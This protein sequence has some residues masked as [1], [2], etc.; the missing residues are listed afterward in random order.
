MGGLLIKYFLVGQYGF[1]GVSAQVFRADKICLGINFFWR[2]KEPFFE[3][4][5]I[6]FRSSQSN[7]WEPGV[8][9]GRL[10]HCNG[11]KF[12]VHWSKDREG[13]MRFE[14]QVRIPVGLRSSASDAPG[15]FSAKRRMGSVRRICFLAARRIYLHS[16]FAKSGGFLFSKTFWPRTDLSTKTVRIKNF[17]AGKMKDQHL[18]KI[19]L[20]A[21]A[22]LFA[23]QLVRA[24]TITENFTNDPAA[25]GW[26]VFGDTSLFQWDSVSHNLDVTWNS[27]NQNSYFYLPLGTTLTASADF[28]V[29]FDLQLSTASASGYG[30]EL[31]AGFFN[32]AEATNAFFSRSSGDN[33]PDL[34]EFDYFP[35]AGF[36]DTIWPALVDSN[37]HFNYNGPSDYAIYTP[38]LNDWYHIVMTYTASNQTLVTTLTNFAQTSGITIVD[39]LN[40]TSTNYPFKNFKVDTFAVSS[41]QDDGY[42]DSVYAQG[43][44]TNLVINFI[45]PPI[46]NFSGGFSNRVWQAQFISQTNWVYALERTVDFASWTAINTNNAG[47]GATLFLLD[48]NPPAAQAFYRVRANEP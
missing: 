30:M 11:Y 18:K 2:K 23:V 45:A 26:Q 12:Q 5:E 22:S 3:T 33:S 36:G 19:R 20:L 10:R 16:S 1:T 32:L 24:T 44:I 43:A 46:Q 9:P 13:G 6:K 37:G 41:Y 27:T 28:S 31:A 42:G 14:A 21:L 48:T 4:A 39:P 15:H 40:L 7:V 47:T 29:A 35:D 17:C 38:A 25:D 34:V 8:N